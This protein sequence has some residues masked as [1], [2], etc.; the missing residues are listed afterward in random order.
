MAALIKRTVTAKTAAELVRR[1]PAEAIELKI[2]VFDWLVEKLDKKVA[3]NPAGYLV[4]SITD[5]YAAP[6]GFV[7]KAARHR[8][9]EAQE[10]KDRQAAEERRRQQEQEANEQA[11]LREADAFWEAL[12]HEEQSRYEVEALAAADEAVR[13]TITSLRR[14]GGGDGFLVTVRRDYIRQ[15]LNSREQVAAKT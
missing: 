9:K 3:R 2:D 14:N 11:E 6:K 4:K 12:T 10:A 13:N 8:F 1:H 15:M 5:D 7:S